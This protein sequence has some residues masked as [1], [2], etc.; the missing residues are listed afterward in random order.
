[1]DRDR[2]MRERRGKSTPLNG[3]PS[4]PVGANRLNLKRPAQ[5]ETFLSKFALPVAI[6]TGV[7]LILYLYVS[8]ISLNSIFFR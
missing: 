1:M 8:S 4:E 2:E 3:A 7:I 6:A 5:N